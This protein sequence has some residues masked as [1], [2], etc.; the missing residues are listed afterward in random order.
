MCV[1]VRTKKS[2]EPRPSEGGGQIKYLMP[3]PATA[4][5]AEAM[6]RAAC[7]ALTWGDRAPGLKA[8]FLFDT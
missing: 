4:M 5:S 2:R 6:G 8:S 7:E 3:P 1:Q